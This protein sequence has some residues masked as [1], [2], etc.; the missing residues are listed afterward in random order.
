MESQVLTKWAIDPTHSEVQ[1]KVK[2]LVIS[3]VTGNFS[4]F[5]GGLEWDG[6]DLEAAKAE[7]SAKV[8][9][10]S[11][12]NADR[13]AHLKSDDFFNASQFPELKFKSTSFT[14]IDD[15]TYKIKGDFTIRDITKPI[16]LT[17]TY[18]GSVTDPY[19]QNKA[20]FE[21]TGKIDR[22]AFGLKWSAV[23]EAGSVV[24]SDEVRLQL[25]IQVVKS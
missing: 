5:A 22:K 8:D 19:G 18:G 25:N 12:N 2:H 10:I 1:F 21:I 4:E 24:V 15:D 13:D 11:T 14:K 9:S 6:E 23:T 20:G 7:F 17:A 16:E 3:T